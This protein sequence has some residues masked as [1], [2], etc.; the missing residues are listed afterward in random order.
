MD[1]FWALRGFFRAH[2]RSYCIA[3]L[4]LVGV[5]V[6]GL[7]PPAIVGRVVDGIDAG[8]LDQRALLLHAGA[9]VA[10]ALGIYLLRFLWRQILYGASYT[11]SLQLRKQI[12]AHMLQLSPAAMA[13]FP[14]GDLMARATN[15]V[16]AVEMTAGEAVLSIFDG[17]LTG[18]LVLGVMVFV[19][20]GW[21]T[22]MALAPWPLMTWA[23]WR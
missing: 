6:L 22:L 1:I 17:L 12:Y 7:L 4:L 16:Q 14:A 13:S 23:M 9:I 19:L 20:S 21:L 18:L 15:D 10:S 8:T 11:L 3:A 2:W 5:A